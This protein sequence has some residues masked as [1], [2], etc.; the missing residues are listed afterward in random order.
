VAGDVVIAG[1][2]DTKGEEIGFLRAAI[3]IRGAGSLLVDTGILGQ[4]ALIPDIDRGTVAEAAGTSIEVL[5]RGDRG[6]AVEWMGRGAARVVADLYA[7]GRLSAIV[8]IGGSGNATIAGMAMRALPIGVPK[9]LVTTVASGDTRPYVGST[10]LTLIYSVVDISGLNRLSRR[11]LTNAA[12]AIV[13]M[14]PA[15]ATTE[16]P[17]PPLVATTMFGVTTPCVTNVREQ[18]ETLG[19]EVLVFHATGVGGRSMESLICDRLV[20]GVL[21][22][23]T[24]ELADEVAGGA[25]SAGPD[26]LDAAAHQGIPQVVSLGALDMANFGPPS[27]V[28]ARFRDR[29]LYSHNSAVTLMRTTPDENAAVGRLMAQKLNR[30]TGPAAVLVPLRGLSAIDVEGGVFYDPDADTA[31]FQALR[32]HLAPRVELIEVD[33]HINDPAFATALTSTFHRLYAH[34][35]DVARDSAR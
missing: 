18:L 33:A 24:T 27:S 17:E 26:R 10:D 12:G 2:L 25:L 3:A 1:T 29:L 7:Q 11:I 16:Q 28:P 4:P 20:T 31:L 21:D 19:Y 23:T 30:A 6:Q 15:G 9:L 13:G 22:I 5:A 32:S 35:K 34:R 8:A 14:L